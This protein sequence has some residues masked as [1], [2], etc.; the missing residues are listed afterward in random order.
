MYHKFFPDN[1]LFIQSKNMTF[2]F[3]D[4]NVIY[5]YIWVV[6]VLARDTIRKI[7]ENRTILSKICNMLLILEYL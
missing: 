4:P 6:I 2:V 1:P 3:N 5:C 7:E